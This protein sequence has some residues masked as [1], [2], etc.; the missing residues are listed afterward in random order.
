MT[1][2]WQ[3]LENAHKEEYFLAKQGGTTNRE[4][5]QMTTVDSIVVKSKIVIIYIGQL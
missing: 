2:M 5:H 4:K 1:S 3:H